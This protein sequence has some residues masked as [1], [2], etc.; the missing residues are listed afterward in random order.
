V[1][2]FSILLSQIDRSSR[3]KLKREIMKLT[4]VMVQMDLT[5]INRAFHPNSKECTFLSAPHRTFSKIDHIVCYKASLNRYKKIDITSCVL[6]DYHGLKL[7]LESRKSRL[8]ETEW[9]QLLMVY[10]VTTGS[11][12]K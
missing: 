8:I 11:R 4:E 1:G 12:K 3:Q 10:S 9:K 6:S 5:D 7:N 2:D